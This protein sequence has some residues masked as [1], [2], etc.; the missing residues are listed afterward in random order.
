MF[1]N[2]RIELSTK[3]EHTLGQ[4]LYHGYYSLHHLHI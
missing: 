3:L 2:E 4:L 1:L